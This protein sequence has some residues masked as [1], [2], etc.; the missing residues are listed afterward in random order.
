MQGKRGLPTEAAQFIWFPNPDDPNSAVF[1][2]PASATNLS[3]AG[4][5]LGTLAV[6]ITDDKPDDSLFVRLPWLRE[7]FEHE[8]HQPTP[9]RRGGGLHVSHLLGDIF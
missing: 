1:L 8:L 7:L 3:D 2:P 5:Q 4:I 6:E 9:R